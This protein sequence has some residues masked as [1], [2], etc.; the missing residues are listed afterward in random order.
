[1]KTVAARALG[2]G[3]ILCA[4]SRGINHQC[5]R[6]SVDATQHR[7][8]VAFIKAPQSNGGDLVF[9]T[10]AVAVLDEIQ[11]EATTVAVGFLLIASLH[12]PRAA[13]IGLG[14]MRGLYGHADEE[15]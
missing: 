11:A 9:A 10:N 1:M 2:R 12:R 8:W 4:R 7:T 13:E 15:D 5:R 6:V 3:Q 14:G